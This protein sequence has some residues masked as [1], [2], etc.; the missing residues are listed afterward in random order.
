MVD[1]GASKVTVSAPAAV[2]HWFGRKANIS[3]VHAGL[4]LQRHAPFIFHF[5]NI[6]LVNPPDSKA[7]STLLDLIVSPEV[8]TSAQLSLCSTSRSCNDWFRV[9]DFIAIFAVCVRETF[10]TRNVGQYPT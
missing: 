6:A 2:V 4:V 9:G 7:I 3:D 10:L 8:T 5:D 1:A